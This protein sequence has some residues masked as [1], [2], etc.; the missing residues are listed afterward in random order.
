MEPGI[1]GQHQDHQDKQ[2]R[3]GAAG[4]IASFCISFVYFVGKYRRELALTP[5]SVV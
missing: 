5:Q 3:Y 2:A 4:T 1:K